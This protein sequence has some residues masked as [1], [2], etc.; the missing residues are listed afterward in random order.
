MESE[1]PSRTVS[2]DWYGNWL[3][4][5]ERDDPYT[6]NCDAYFDRDTCC[7][8]FVDN[9]ENDDVGA[10]QVLAEVLATPHRYEE[11]PALTHA[12]H[13]RIFADWIATLPQK[14]QDVCNTVSIGGFRET[15]EFDFPDEAVEQ[16]EAWHDYHGSALQVLA[17]EWLRDRGI[18]VASWS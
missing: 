9:E 3:L 10:R 18:K 7:L 11:I 14:I 1:V 2:L 12:D 6:N 17:E 4:A 16:W 15:L 13:H 5:W 8:L